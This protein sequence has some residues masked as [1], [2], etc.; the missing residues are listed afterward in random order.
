[1]K[2]TLLGTFVLLIAG[3]TTV[4]VRP[5]LTPEWS[6]AEKRGQEIL[7]K[8]AS[9]TPK[10]IR[11][12]DVTTFRDETVVFYGWPA[13]PGACNDVETGK[14]AAGNSISG[15]YIRV[16]NPSGKDL[17]GPSASWEVYIRGKILQVYP[18]NKVIVLQIKDDDYCIGQMF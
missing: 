16:V 9:L 5:Y 6:P 12:F 3:C 11:N 7:S 4:R 18:A 17:R 13:M 8:L 15:F 14:T 1:M 2:L 10:Q